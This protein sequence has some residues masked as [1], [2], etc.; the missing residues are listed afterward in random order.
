MRVIVYGASGMVGYGVLRECLEDPGVAD[1]VA[2]GRA[3]LGRSHPKLRELVLPDVGNLEGRASELTGFDATFWCLGVSSVGMTEE[4]Y[5]RV[6]YDLTLAAARSLAAWNPGMTF[7]YV[8]GV[9]TDSTERG[10]TMWARVK[11]ATENALAR[12]PF[13]ATFDFRPGIIQARHGARSRT[14]AYRALYVVLFPILLLIRA[15]APNSVTTT[16]RIGRA[17]IAVVR[18]PPAERIVG[19]REINALAR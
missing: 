8:S 3:A 17:M 15:V 13:R 18:T 7:V 14:S 16:D 5:R 4:A 12:L 11:G 9:G 10:T 19:T 6:T 1:V 2:I